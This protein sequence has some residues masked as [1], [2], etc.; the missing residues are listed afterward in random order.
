MCCRDWLA[1]GH[2][3]VVTFTQ[4]QQHLWQ[5]QS[6]ESHVPAQQDGGSQPCPGAVAP[7]SSSGIHGEM[8]H[9]HGCPCTHAVQPDLKIGWFKKCITLKLCKW[10]AAAN[11][12]CWQKGFQFFFPPRQLPPVKIGLQFINKGTV[13][14]NKL[15]CLNQDREA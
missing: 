4:S 13:V 3:L 9:P 7:C 1:P 8:P 12:A 10:K 14:L 11:R 5:Q 6:V 2:K 15:P